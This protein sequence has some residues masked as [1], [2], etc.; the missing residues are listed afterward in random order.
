[1]PLETLPFEPED[2][3][4]SEADVVDWLNVWMEDGSPDE[5]ANAIGDIARSK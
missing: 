2:Y 4:N 3:L 1:M 5:I